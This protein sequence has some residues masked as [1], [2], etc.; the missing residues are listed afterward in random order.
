LKHAGP[1]TLAT[2]EP[3]LLA[4]R[5][6]GGLKEKSPGAFYL[7]SAAFL[8]FH[9]DPGGIF[10]DVK[11]DGVNFTRLNATTAD[12]QARLLARVD[13]CLAAMKQQRPVV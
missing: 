1:A 7:K 8:H 10:V 9:E 2:L 11:L 4:L 6:R 12:E 5:Q 13:A 3:L